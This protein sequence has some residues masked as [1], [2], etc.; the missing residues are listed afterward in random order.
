LPE[1][2]H[3]SHLMNIFLRPGF[4]MPDIFKALWHDYFQVLLNSIEHWVETNVLANPMPQSPAPTSSWGERLANQAWVRV[5][6]LANS[7]GLEPL[8]CFV[9]NLLQPL[10]P[11]MLQKIVPQIDKVHDWVL[12]AWDKAVAKVRHTLVSKLNPS[13]TST[14]LLQHAQVAGEALC[15]HTLQSGMQLAAA[16]QTF[17]AKV[18]DA[19]DMAVH[20]FSAFLRGWWSTIM[21][22]VV[23]PIF[24]K[25]EASMSE[26]FKLGMNELD[27]LS[28][29][30]PE[31][32]APVATQAIN[33][34]EW[35]QAFVQKAVLAKSMA[36]LRAVPDK[37]EP[38]LENLVRTETSQVQNAVAGTF[39]GAFLKEVENV[40]LV[41]AKDLKQALG[42]AAGDCTELQNNLLA[43]L[44][45]PALEP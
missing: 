18:V 35:A 20:A 37:I 43:S 4:N 42:A 32:G 13:G 9:D 25:I 39:G 2:Y 12:S 14:E 23:L 27:G 44:H 8:K 3:A 26:L 17:K 19:A 38:H 21:A 45:L 41:L 16:G 5:Q 24:S 7:T 33:A 28:G 34:L 22:K 31:V 6:N 15:A 10:W 36:E 40:V 30:I 1:Q 29:L 11:T